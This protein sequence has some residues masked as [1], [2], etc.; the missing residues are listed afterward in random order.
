MEF[1]P[2]GLSSGGTQGGSAPSG[3]ILQHD[4]SQ[5]HP[6]KRDLCLFLDVETTP[7]KPAAISCNPLG[8]GSG[9]PLRLRGPERVGTI[10]YR[11]ESE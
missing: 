4:I 2:T 6:V 9:Q 7:I 11:S 1:Y 8:C 10:P 3:N 5:S